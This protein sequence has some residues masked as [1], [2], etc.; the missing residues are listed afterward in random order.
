M[1]KYI[2]ILTIAMLV[3]VTTFYSSCKKEELYTGVWKMTLNGTCD[4]SQ[5]VIINDDGSFGFQ[6]T[7]GN[8]VNKIEGQ[9]DLKTGKLAAS[10]AVG[11]L[12]ACSKGV[13]GSLNLN[14]TGSGTFDCLFVM[15]GGWTAVR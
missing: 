5:T 10:I 4:G 7:C 13:N 9:V 8:T 15:A 3:S 14:G 1:K 2:Q 12:T 6:V 11:G